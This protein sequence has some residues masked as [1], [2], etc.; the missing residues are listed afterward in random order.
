MKVVH[1]YR[2]YEGKGGHSFME[3]GKHLLSIDEKVPVQTLHYKISPPRSISEKHNAPATNY[4]ITV[5]GTVRFKTSLGV[6]FIVQPGD[7]LIAEDVAGE[8]HSWELVGDDPWIRF[9]VVFTPV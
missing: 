3:D 5:K 7:L 2:L 8:G 9:Y 6:E 1:V 4:V